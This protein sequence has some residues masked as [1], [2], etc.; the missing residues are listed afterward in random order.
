MV[1]HVGTAILTIP[2]IV[3]L[4]SRVLDVRKTLT[5]VRLNRAVGGGCVLME[6][7]GTPVSVQQD[8]LEVNVRQKSTCAGGTN[9]R[10]VAHAI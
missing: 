9:V 10:M 3:P 8:I 6:W 2:V 7:T 4:A 5:T 1:E